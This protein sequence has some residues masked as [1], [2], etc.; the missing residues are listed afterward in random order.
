MIPYPGSKWCVA[1]V[2]VISHSISCTTASAVTGTET[3]VGDNGDSF[4]LRE[5]LSVGGVNNG[6]E[7]KRRAG[8]PVGESVGEGMGLEW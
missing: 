1:S 5:G 7:S 8:L 6:A 2:C 4:V 3:S